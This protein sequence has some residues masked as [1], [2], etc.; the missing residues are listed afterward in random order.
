MERITNN[1]KIKNRMNVEKTDRLNTITAANGPFRTE[2]L[3]H[4]FA[5]LLL[6][7]FFLYMLET[8][9]FSED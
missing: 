6:L 3:W 9:F 5:Q 7:K 2:S 4:T 8:V 1:N